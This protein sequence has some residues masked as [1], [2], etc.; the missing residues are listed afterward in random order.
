MFTIS[1]TKS[2]KSLPTQIMFHIHSLEL[3]PIHSLSSHLTWIRSIELFSF[4]RQISFL[5][6]LII[7]HIQS[8]NV[9]VN[10]ACASPV[11][12]ANS[13]THSFGSTAKCRIQYELLS[14]HLN[15]SLINPQTSSLSSITIFF[16]CCYT[17]FFNQLSQHAVF[18]PLKARTISLREERARENS[19][20]FLVCLLL[21]AAL[22]SF[23][24]SQFGR[25]SLKWHCVEDI[26]CC[27]MQ[28]RKHT[29]THS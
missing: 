8:S 6:K 13:H 17:A 29:Q 28:A 3:S 25:F 21:S 1:T 27:S 5:F 9:A 12:T 11:F 15:N 22:Q 26:I 19:F 23:T 10:N 24:L 14:I 16:C 4:Q 18:R 7:N 20:F 2:I